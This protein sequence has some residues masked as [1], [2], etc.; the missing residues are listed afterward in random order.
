MRGVRAR[1][2]ARY[3]ALTVCSDEDRALVAH[4][5][6]VC[7]ANGA[8][9]RGIA[10]RPSRVA[11]LLFVGPFR[12]RP[13]RE[14]IVRFLREAWPRVREAVPE[15]TLTILGGD[16]SHRAGARRAGVRAS[17]ACRCSDIATTC[18]ACSRDARSRSIR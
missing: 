8:T 11:A 4:P 10:Y 3:D 9:V 15:A 14:G 6:V 2:V 5:R 17:R 18:R 12:Y 16:E 1:P 7:V 13:N